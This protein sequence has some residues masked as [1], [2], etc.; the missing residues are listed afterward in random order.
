MSIRRKY[1]KRKSKKRS[2]SKSRYI[3]DKKEKEIGECTGKKKLCVCQILIVIQ[4]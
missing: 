4:Q 1:K 3:Y 2:K